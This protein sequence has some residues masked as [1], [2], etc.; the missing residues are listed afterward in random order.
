MSLIESLFHPQL[1]F[2]LALFA[3]VS[4]VVEIAAYKLLLSVADVPP[5][6]WIMERVIVPAARALALVSFILVAYPVLFGMKSAL[7]VGDLLVVGQ[8]PMRPEILY[9]SYQLTDK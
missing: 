4:V 8:L 1:L 5:S 6:H 2:A 9:P 3:I 7:P